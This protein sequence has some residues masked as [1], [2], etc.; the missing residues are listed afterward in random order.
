VP[1]LA[2]LRAH[3]ACVVSVPTPLL[4]RPSH[5]GTLESSPSDALLVVEELERVL[6]APLA[7]GARLAAGLA[8]DAQRPATPRAGIA[9]RALRRLAKS[10]G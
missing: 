2:R 3:G 4:P 7:S 1:P 5:P 10:L 9:R 8:A 6:P